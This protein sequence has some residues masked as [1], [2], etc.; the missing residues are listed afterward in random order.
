MRV[1]GIDTSLRSTGLGVVQADGSRLSAVEYQT[2]MTRPDKRHTECLKNLS[3]GVSS[4][5]SRT[6]PDVAVVEGVFFAKNIKTTMILGE[7]RGAVIS[8]CAV[9]GIPVYEYAPR[10]IKMA[11]TGSGAASKLQVRKMVISMLGL[12][13]EPCE[14]EG[15][16]LAIA[17]CHLHNR[18]GIAALTPQ[19]I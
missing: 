14:D 19:E 6:G 13:E 5:I 10:K 12:R 2:I 17:I 4:L 7:A 9:K 16:A 15:D 8:V 1:L 11:L 3:E 18:S